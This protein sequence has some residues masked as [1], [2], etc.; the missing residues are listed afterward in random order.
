MKVIVSTNAIFSNWRSSMPF[1]IRDKEVIAMANEAKRRFGAKT[2]EEAI[3][4]ALKKFLE[5]I[6]DGAFPAEHIVQRGDEIIPSNPKS[7]DAE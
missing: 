4:I 7:T 6:E 5:Q 2:E 3:G 1:C